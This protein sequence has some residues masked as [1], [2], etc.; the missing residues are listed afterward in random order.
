M[1]RLVKH[2]KKLPT[3]KLLKELDAKK[4]YIYFKY[5]IARQFF[6]KCFI[7]LKNKIIDIF[8]KCN[9]DVSFKSAPPQC[10]DYQIPVVMLEANERTKGMLEQINWKRR[11]RWEF[12]NNK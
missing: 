8:P 2:S 11:T 7:L 12:S 1:K 9:L 5:T 6:L 10:Q 3:D 4:I